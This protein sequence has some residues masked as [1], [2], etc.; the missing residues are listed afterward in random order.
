VG[1]PNVGKSSIFN[2]LSDKYAEVSNYQ[3]TTVS[4]TTAQIHIGTLIDTPGIYS[5]NGNSKIEV[6]TKKHIDEADLVINVVNSTTLDRDLILTKQLINAYHDKLIIVLNQIDEAKKKELDINYEELKKSGIEIIK[7]VAIKGVGKKEI[8]HAIMSG[9]KPCG[10]ST[11]V[12]DKCMT[13][14][15]SISKIDKVLLNPITGWVVIAFVLYALFKILGDFVAGNV[16]DNLIS[17]IDKFYIPIVSQFISNI[18]G[19]NFWT[20]ILV[21]EFGMLTMTVKIV[22]GI[23]MPLIIG[24]YIILSLLEDSGYIPRLSVLISRFFNFLGLNGDAIIPI[25]L[26]FGCGALGTISCRILRTRKEQIIVTALIGIAVPCAAQQCIIIP[27]LAATTDFRIWSMYIA[28]MLV[29]TIIFGKILNLFIKGKSSDFFIMDIPPLRIPSITNCYKKT[30]YRAKN[31]LRES[32]SIF[33]VSSGII[34]ILHKYGVLNW[35]QASLSPIVENL[36]H[37]PKEFAEVF[38]MG[39]IKRDLA[40]LGAFDMSQKFLITRPQILIAAV[41]LTLSVPCI[42]AVI[43][44]L[45]EQGWK[46]ALTL[47]LSTFVIS[48]T[49]GAAL[50]RISECIL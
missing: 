46:M 31:F 9:P 4:V 41:V 44:I 22:F 27:L 35:I 19:H 21:G 24:F 26:G 43:V 50:A 16:V 12:L 10:A 3:G 45:K 17:V 2:M 7:T 13:T 34:T 29:V 8:F 23:L 20:E 36:L 1:N 40:A 38:V 25:L 6:I 37:L 30:M 15:C 42:N 33:I 48:I 11:M 5:L 28:T 14:E 18:L 32:L 47:W 49:V 39:I